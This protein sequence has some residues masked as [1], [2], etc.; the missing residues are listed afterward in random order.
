MDPRSRYRHPHE[1]AGMQILGETG[2]TESP[3][4]F[5]IL[6]IDREIFSRMRAKENFPGECQRLVYDFFRQKVDELVKARDQIL[7]EDP[8]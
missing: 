6:G 4:P 1:I 5:Q 7:E 8:E 3:D 2:M